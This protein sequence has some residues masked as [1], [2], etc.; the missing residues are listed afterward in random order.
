MYKNTLHILGAFGWSKIPKTVPIFKQIE[1][2]LQEKGNFSIKNGQ[3]EKIR[4]PSEQPGTSMSNKRQKF[5]CDPY[6]LEKKVP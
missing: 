6:L 2:D 5:S 3:F 4:K 1:L